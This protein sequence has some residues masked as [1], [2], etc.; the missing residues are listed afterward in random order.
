MKIAP[1]YIKEAKRII[2]N[3]N[4][5]IQ[6]L[7]VFENALFENKNM[8]LK[9]KSEIDELKNSRETDISKKQK[10]AEVMVGYDKEITRLQNIIMPYV[11]QLEKLKKDSTIL[12]KVL[13]EKYPGFSDTQLQEQIFKQLDEEQKSA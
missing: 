3:Y 7:T 9:L 12:Y 6:E 10:L 2:K 4:N 13:K 5:S 11:T 1:Q 8:L